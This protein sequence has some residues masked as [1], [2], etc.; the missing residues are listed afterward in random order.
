MTRIRN[1]SSKPKQAPDFYVFQA[2]SAGR[3]D[4]LAGVAFVHR[5]GH[6]LALMIDGKRYVA[7]PPKAANRHHDF[8]RRRSRTVKKQPVRLSRV[9]PCV[10]LLLRTCSLV[11]RLIHEALAWF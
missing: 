11:E 3:V 9:L 4:Q 2:G 1:P 6:G 8:R 7:F 5:S 10:G